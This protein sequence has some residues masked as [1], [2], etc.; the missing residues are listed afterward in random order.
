M[1]SNWNELLTGEMLTFGL[2]SKAFYVYPEKTWLQSLVEGDIFS[3]A[4]FASNQAE[5]ESA[6]ELLQAWSRGISDEALEDVR[7]DYTRLFI[8]PGKVL[9]PP[10][11]SVY[12]SEERLTFQEET[13]KVREWYRRF[14]LQAEKIYQE[15]DDH[16]GLEL[17]FIAHLAKLGLRALEQNDKA[18]FEET[19]DAQ[20]RFMVEHLLRWAFGWCEQVHA[21]SHTDFY[22]GIA[23]LTRG[24]VR[25]AATILDV[26]IPVGTKA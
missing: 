22:R 2:L 18:K 12:F 24:A 3:E 26:K 1:E 20:K 11:Q 15:P 6:L 14:G 19:L 10:W 4:P 17:E 16:I 8:G 7:M 21:Q 25:E 5:V 23:L 13:L 9:T